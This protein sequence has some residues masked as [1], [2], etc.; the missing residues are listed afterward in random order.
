M[1]I[2]GGKARGILLD[3][4][5]DKN[6]RPSTDY[7][8][9]AVFSSLGNC[10]EAARV[11]DIFAGTGSYGLEALSRG[12]E[13]TTFLE[14]NAKLYPVLQAN[15]AKV[16]KS[17]GLIQEVYAIYMMDAL[18]WTGQDQSF[19][20]IFVDPPYAFFQDQSLD[21][22][23]KDLSRCLRQGPQARLVVEHPGRL[24][25]LELD[26]FSL[27]KRLGKNK[28]HQPCASIYSLV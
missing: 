10:V 25:A 1:R 11:L 14:K 16:C 13:H 19:D 3:S 27:V 17:A 20:I 8:R 28:P 12:A 6:L 23:F 24:K 21:K 26:S 2:T 5:E 22:F 15:A 4:L 9:Q 18:K 7:I